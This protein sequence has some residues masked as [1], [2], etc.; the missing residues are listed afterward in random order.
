[1]DVRADYPF[2]GRYIDVHGVKMHYIEQGI[3]QVFLFLHGNPTW[4]YLWR[5]IIPTVAEH[6]RCIALDLVGFGRSQRP[7]IGYTFP[8]HY[9]FV[10]GFIEKM[11]LKDIV[12]VG[13]DWGG[14][15][16][17]Y[18]ALHHRDNVKGIAFMESFPFTVRWDYFPAQFRIGF[19]L[20]RTPVVGKFLIMTLN[21]FVNKIMLS[22]IVRRLPKDVHDNYKRMFPTVKSRY[23][24]YV[25]PNEI[26]IEGE[27]GV[28]F[29][30]VKRIQD[31]LSGFEFPMLLV[32]ANPGAIIRPEKVE[33]L[34][35]TI[36][37]LTVM[38]I[39]SGLHY[40]QEDN[41]R[42][43]ANSIVEWAR[44]KG[45]VGGRLKKAA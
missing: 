22:S 37:D 11:G 14:V 45:I 18:Y 5:N 21:L 12:I 29:D 34:R 28:T 6:G 8:E 27:G 7:D 24:V 35:N 42:G 44:D 9:H 20:F 19:K 36:R 26:P 41:P 23:P 15:I 2:E 17:F 31:A 43:I 1:M 38:D 33:W 30:A 25:F 13:H 32:K 3:G 10:D 4:S 40:L 39:G 16:G